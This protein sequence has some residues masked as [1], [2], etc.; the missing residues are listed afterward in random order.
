MTVR[1]HV[2]FIRCVCVSLQQPRQT[3]QPAAVTRHV[4]GCWISPSVIRG[5]WPYSWQIWKSKY[6]EGAF[7]WHGNMQVICWEPRLSWRHPTPLSTG[8]LCSVVGGSPAL[9]V[10]QPGG[11]GK[12][13]TI[14]VL[15]FLLRIYVFVL[16]LVCRYRKLRTSACWTVLLFVC[17]LFHFIRTIDEN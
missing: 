11:K 16:K 13:L 5:L 12:D 10:H 14:C 8:R 17:L 1:L 4:I 15:F 7:I 9:P 2:G 3:C 6:R